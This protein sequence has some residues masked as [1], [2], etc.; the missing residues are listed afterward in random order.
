MSDLANSIEKLAREETLEA[1]QNLALQISQNASPGEP[2]EELLKPFI[3]KPYEHIQE[4][5]Q[6]ARLVLLTAAADSENEE[7]V[8][9]AIQGAGRKQL[10]LG[11]AEIVALATLGLFALN[12]L[13]TKGKSSERHTVKIDEQ[14]GKTTFVI[15]NEVSY[16][17]SPSLGQ[18]LK[19]YF[20]R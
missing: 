9:S 6:L 15:E 7:A 4:I 8:R 3:E 13:V 19:S 10:I 20:G 2:E 18:L 16:G 12:L 1:A 11:G 14:D 5:E 17:I